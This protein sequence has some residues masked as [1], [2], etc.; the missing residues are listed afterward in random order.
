MSE[1]SVVMNTGVEGTLSEAAVK[2]LADALRGRLL[3]VGDE[4]YDAARTIWNGMI[5]K[6]PAL[7]ARCVGAA[8]VIACVN[9]AR[10]NALVVAVRGGGHNISGNAVCDGG[11]M[12]DL[13][14]MKSIRVDLA[15]G[16]ARAEAGVTWGEFDRETQSFGLATTGG[17]ITTTG[18]AGLTLGGGWGWLGRKY[19]LACDNLLSADIVTASGGLLTASP[20]QNEDLFWGIRGGG[21][22]FG[23]ATSFE[24]Q[25]HPVGAVFGGLVAFP[26]EMAKKVLAGYRDLMH[27][28]PDELAGN[29]AIATLPDGTPIVG[30]VVCYC[31]PP[32][33]GERILRPLREFGPPIIDL[34]GPTSYTAI[35]GI[36]DAFTPAGIQSYWKACFLPEL[37]EEAIDTMI[38]YCAHRPVPACMGILEYQLGGAA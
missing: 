28:A 22:N 23:V 24:Y 7:I 6:R 13:S 3:R 18:I 10:A 14:R 5:D 30:L 37:N 20:T 33:K 9:V 17:Q 21:G 1:L 38:A 35:Q 19:G 25:L 4:G 26:L 29:A 11:L 8:D 15:R 27:T 16:T 32:E 36:Q 34:V 12:I 2:Q 31:G